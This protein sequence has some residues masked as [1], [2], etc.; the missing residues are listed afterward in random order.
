VGKM[1]ERDHLED[2]DIDGEIN[3]EC[4]LKKGWDCV[5]WIDLAQ[6]RGRWEVVVGAVVNPGFP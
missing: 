2:L 6:I 1:K 4:T 3:I 5:N